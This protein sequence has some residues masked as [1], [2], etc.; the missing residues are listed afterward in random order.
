MPSRAL[1]A[2]QVE[3]SSRL[4]RLLSA[5]AAVGGTGPGRRWATAE[6]NHALVLRLA[7]EFQGFARELHDEA[8]TALTTFVAGGRADLAESL[9]APY[10]VARQLERGNAH[11]ASLGHDFGLFGIYL[12]DELATAYPARTPTWRARLVALNH[13]RNALAHDNTDKL[14]RVTVAGW[15][16][17]LRSVRRWRKSLDGL[18]TAMDHVTRRRL[19]RLTGTVPW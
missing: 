11:P 10:V 9:G 18:T 13:A 6:L 5:H 4:D 7:S 8:V 19:V 15:P 3:R 16:M 12:W 14:A 2:W 1:R 17:T